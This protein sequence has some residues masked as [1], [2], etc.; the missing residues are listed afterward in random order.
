MYSYTSD[1]NTKLSSSSLL[2]PCTFES[3]YLRREELRRD[4]ACGDN[5][6]EDNLTVLYPF[7]LL[8]S[9]SNR[10]VPPLDGVCTIIFSVEDNPLLSRL[11][12]EGEDTVLSTKGVPTLDLD[13][14]SVIPSINHLDSKFR[15]QNSWV[16]DYNWNRERGNYRQALGNPEVFVVLQRGDVILPGKEPL[17]HVKD[18]GRAT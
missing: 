7:G 11:V 14:I 8:N 1:M 6:T 3:E 10:L 18:N 4:G 17:V 5:G 9:P 13:D 16:K 12:C 2:G 15:R